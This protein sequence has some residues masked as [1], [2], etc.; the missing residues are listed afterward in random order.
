MSFFLYFSLDKIDLSY[1]LVW[2][3]TIWNFGTIS[4][5]FMFW[6]KYLIHGSSV[7]PIIYLLSTL[8]YILFIK[9]QTLIIVVMSFAS[10]LECIQVK[11]IY[12][13]IRLYVNF[14]SLTLQKTFIRR[15]LYKDQT[16]H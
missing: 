6:V 14:D 1:L 2:G 3:F 13:V 12:R 15:D 9:Q 16:S 4:F 5:E 11:T 7:F 8:S 10:L